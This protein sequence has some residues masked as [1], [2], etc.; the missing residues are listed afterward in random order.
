MAEARS[1]KW[2][3]TKEKSFI[4]L[5][6]DAGSLRHVAIAKGA[7]IDELEDEELTLRVMER[8]HISRGGFQNCRKDGT[9]CE[10]GQ[11]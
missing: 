5:H 2:K 1:V 8:A 7:F 11:T 4:L 6:P 10:E 9:L 3:T